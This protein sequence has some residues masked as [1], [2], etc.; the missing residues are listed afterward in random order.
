MSPDNRWVIFTATLFGTAQAYG[1][2][3]PFEMVAKR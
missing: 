1:V 3:V 2:E